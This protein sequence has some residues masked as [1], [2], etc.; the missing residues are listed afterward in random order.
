MESPPSKKQKRRE[1]ETKDTNIGFTPVGKLVE[2]LNPSQ[3]YKGVAI[4]K[5][6]LACVLTLLVGAFTLG[7]KVSQWHS[8]LDMKNHMLQDSQQKI[9]DAEERSRHQREIEKIKEEKETLQKQLE[10]AKASEKLPP[11]ETTRIIVA[12]KKY[13]RNHQ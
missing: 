9:Q 10:E 7:F 4:A 1:P 8:D 6:A 5:T 12:P 11:K 3:I 2:S 13:L